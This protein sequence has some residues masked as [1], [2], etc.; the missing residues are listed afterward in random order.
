[1]LETTFEGNGYVVVFS[2]A[3][4]R[5]DT[6]RRLQLIAKIE[7][8]LLALENRVRRGDLAAATEIAAAATILARSPVKRLF[9]ISDVARAGSSTTTTMNSSTTTRRLPAT[10]CWLPPWTPASPTR[11]RSWPATGPFKQSSTGSSGSSFLRLRRCLR[12]QGCWRGG[13]RRNGHGRGSL[14]SVRVS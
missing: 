2:G 13:G 6:A 11:P 5:R 14:T 9:D 12:C 4:Q 8:K 10:T 7:G 3:R 1:M